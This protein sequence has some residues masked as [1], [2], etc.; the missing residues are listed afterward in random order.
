MIGCNLL[1]LSGCVTVDPFS[2]EYWTTNESSTKNKS[3]TTQTGTSR[4]A[5]VDKT[6][7]TNGV[8][9]N[10][11]TSL[12]QPRMVPNDE[13]DQFKAAIAGQDLTKIAM[14]EHLKKMYVSLATSHDVH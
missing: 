12:K 11:S 14:I 7:Q 13:L 10:A 1:T 8:V 4:P 2:T 9:P 5:L 3:L 6:K